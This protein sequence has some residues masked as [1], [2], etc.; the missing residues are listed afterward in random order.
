MDS[1]LQRVPT[2]LRSR[3]ERRAAPNAPSPVPSMKAL[4]RL[5]IKVNIDF[6]PRFLLSL[7]RVLWH[8]CSYRLLKRF[9]RCKGLKHNGT[10]WLIKFFIWKMSWLIW[11]RMNVV[12]NRHLWSRRIRSLAFF[13]IPL[14]VKII[15]KKRSQILIWNWR[16]S[17]S[18]FRMVLGVLVQ[19]LLFEIAQYLHGNFINFSYL[20][21]SNVFL[22]QASFIDICKYRHLCK[23]WIWLHFYWSMSDYIDLLKKKNTYV[24]NQFHF[25]A[26]FDHHNCICRFLCIFDSVEN[27][28]IQFILFSTTPSNKWIQFD[29]FRNDG[30]SIDA[31]DVL[32]LSQFDTHGFKKRE[33]IGDSL[34]ESMRFLFLL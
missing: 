14:S 32:E 18:F 23:I 17:F 15:K 1:I 27:Q 30:V 7:Y 34:Y 10:F 21:R 33:D 28:I 8:L 24:N 16:K 5:H 29:I 2:E 4:I 13:I 26:F 20:V 12:S 25:P 6:M 22:Y 19:K 11:G 9:K 3:M 31:S